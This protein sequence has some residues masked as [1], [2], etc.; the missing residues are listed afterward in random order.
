MKLHLLDRTDTTSTI[1]IRKDS[2]QNFLK[3]WHHHLELELVVILKSKG[4]RLIGDSIKKFQPKDIVLI[5][6]NLPHMW[7]SDPEYFQGTDTLKAE[8]ISIHFTEDF[9]GKTFLQLQEI[10]PIMNLFERAKQGI[11]FKN[12]PKILRESIVNLY[13]ETGFNKV[14]QFIAILNQL[15]LHDDFKLLSNYG[16]VA[17]LKFE[18]PKLS[19]NAVAYIFKNFN[20][21]ID[22]NKVAN[23][24]H[25]NPSAFSRSFK[26]VHRK[27]F[28]KYINE[29]RIG[30]ACKLL[31]DNE[32]SIASIAYESGFNNISNFNRQF[33][34]IK[35]MSP[36][37]YLKIH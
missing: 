22:L 8:A 20:K 24:V 12:V 6:K 7:L 32:L 11:Y 28:S 17:S 19:D 26:R 3:I 31:I 15:A 1:S 5:G 29:I 36:S 21:D 18:E 37:A 25:M 10:K 4:T 27:T 14:H 34:D 16:Y 30:Y 13:G 2:S 33:K 9:L 35:K 23:A